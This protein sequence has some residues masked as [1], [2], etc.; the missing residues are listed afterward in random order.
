MQA[1]LDISGSADL[2]ASRAAKVGVHVTPLSAFSVSARPAEALAL[3]FAAV[4]PPEQ[5]RAMRSLAGALEKK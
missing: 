2:V 4:P 1:V 3:G 5:R